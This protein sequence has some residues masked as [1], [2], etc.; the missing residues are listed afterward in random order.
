M[1]RRIIQQSK[2]FGQGGLH[3][4]RANVTSNPLSVAF[5]HAGPVPLSLAIGPAHF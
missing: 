2:Q 1:A 5:M 4:L 3:V